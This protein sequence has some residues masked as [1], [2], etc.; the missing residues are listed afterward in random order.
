MYGEM[1]VKERGNL[2]WSGRV[3][4]LSYQVIPPERGAMMCSGRG[5]HRKNITGLLSAASR[6]VN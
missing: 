4:R 6:F 2:T 5:L 1:A 3:S